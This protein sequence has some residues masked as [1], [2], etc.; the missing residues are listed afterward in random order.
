ML[1]AVQIQ[2]TLL[3]LLQSDELGFQQTLKLA[4]VFAKQVE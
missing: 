2:L 4:P 3:P 1:A